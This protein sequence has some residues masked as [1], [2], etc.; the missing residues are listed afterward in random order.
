MCAALGSYVFD[1]DDKGAADQVKN[2]WEKQT[3]YVTTLY[4]TDIDTEL[5][6]NTRISIPKPRYAQEDFE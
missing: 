4:G 2:T 6:T 1:H 5:A 3:N